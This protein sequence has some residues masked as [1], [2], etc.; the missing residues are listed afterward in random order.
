MSDA[1][2]FDDGSGRLGRGVDAAATLLAYAG[3]FCLVFIIVLTCVSIAGRA[4]LTLGFG[5]GPVPGDFEMV[6]IASGVA[7]F[8]FL[9]LCQLKRGHVTVDLF[10]GAMGRRGVAITDLAGNALMTG[11]SAIILWRL[12]AGLQDKMRTGEESF[13]LAIPVWWGYALSLVGA[14]VFLLACLVTVWRSVHV[15]LILLQKTR[16]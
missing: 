10:A 14:A 16:A 12:L 13:I 2:G 9:P 8:L 7:V 11:A 15:C 4:L 5:F 3:G 6:E 1:A